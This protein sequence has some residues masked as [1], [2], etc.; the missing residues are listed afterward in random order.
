MLRLFTVLLLVAALATGHGLSIDKRQAS[1]S[2]TFCNVRDLSIGQGSSVTVSSPNYGLGN[3]LD[4][5]ACRITFRT[6]VDPLIVGVNFT[7]IFYLEDNPTCGFDYLCI[8][9]AKFC[10]SYAT[11]RYFEFLVPAGKN[12]THEFRSDGSVNGQGFRYLL[13][14]RRYTNGTVV[15]TPSGTGAGGSN[16][17]FTSVNGSSVYEDKCNYSPETFF[18]VQPTTTNYNY[19]T[20]PNYNYTTYPYY[21]YT[22]YPYYNYTTYPY[23]NYTTYPYYN[24]T[25]Y[26]YY[27]YTTY[28]YY[29]PDTSYNYYTTAPYY[30]Q[31]CNTN[32]PYLVFQAVQYL[33]QELDNRNNA[34]DLLNQFLARNGF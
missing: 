5:T 34:L 30:P 9:G 26:P 28:P 10:G 16:V 1:S 19:T 17:T 3:Y 14:A 23:Y 24:Y 7:N 2:A 22:T 21:N 33:R 27:N 11:S 8:N 12:F 15:N 31:P 29:Y 32:Y 4:N 20:Y 18:N 6:G 13:T 25:T